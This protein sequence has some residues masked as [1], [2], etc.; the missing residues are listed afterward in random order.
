MAPDDVAIVAVEA[1]EGALRAQGVNVARFRITGGIGPA[2]APEGIIGLGHVLAMFPDFIAGVEIDADESFLSMGTR[3]DGIAGAL[4]AGAGERVNPAI[5]DD[6]AGHAAD[7]VGPDE[8]FALGIF[9]GGRGP[10]AGEIF[11][12]GDA[13]LLGAAPAIPVV[14]IRTLLS[15]LRFGRIRQGERIEDRGSRIEKE[16]CVSCFDS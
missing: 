7:V 2:D 1:E 10:V 12:A 5:H 8:I 11:L 4:L 16:I 13:V 9:P 6:G 15:R 3:D 14:G